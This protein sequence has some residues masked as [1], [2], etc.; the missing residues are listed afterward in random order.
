MIF[1]RVNLQI[2]LPIFTGQGAGQI[3]HTPGDDPCHCLPE[4]GRTTEEG[5]WMVSGWISNRKEHKQMKILTRWEDHNAAYTSA[6]K[7]GEEWNAQR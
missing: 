6:E 1:F 7:K 5:A 3:S 4:T 2:K